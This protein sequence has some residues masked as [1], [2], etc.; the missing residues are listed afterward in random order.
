M[1]T[2]SHRKK[3]NLPARSHLSLVTVERTPEQ[4]CELEFTE[5]VVALKTPSGMERPRRFYKIAD[6]ELHPL[7]VVM[8]VIDDALRTEIDGA[9]IL[10]AIVEPL[11]RLIARKTQRRL[12]ARRDPKLLPGA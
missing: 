12:P 5:A 10:R 11:R 1:S 8:R 7:R 2:S 6:D 9:A 4:H 3:E